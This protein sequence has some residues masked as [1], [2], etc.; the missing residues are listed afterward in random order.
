MMPMT[1]PVIACPLLHRRMR[2]SNAKPIM[3]GSMR[4]DG[5]AS[6]NPSYAVRCARQWTTRDQILRLAA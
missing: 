3:P 5:F 2:S 4:R 1:R 6:L